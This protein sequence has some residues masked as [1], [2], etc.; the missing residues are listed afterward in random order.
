MLSNLQTDLND[1]GI[2]GNIMRSQSTTI[3]RSLKIPFCIWAL[4][5]RHVRNVYEI[6]YVMLIETLII[7]VN[8]L[9]DYQCENG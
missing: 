2:L 8:I 4:S 6:L 1:P 3:K 7:N 9:P 5:F